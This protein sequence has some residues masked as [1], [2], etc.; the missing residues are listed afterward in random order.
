M[1]LGAYQIES[2][3]KIL[4]RKQNSLNL[5]LND[6]LVI[7][8]ENKRGILTTIKQCALPSEEWPHIE[9]EL[10]IPVRQG[11]Y[12]LSKSWRIK[13]D[14]IPRQLVEPAYQ[15]NSD[16]FCAYLDTDK[17]DAELHLR[18]WQPGDRYQPMGMHGKTIK[19]S[20]FWV[21]QKLPQRARKF[22]PLVFSGKQLVW[23]PGFQPSHQARITEGTREILM[24]K[25]EKIT[26]EN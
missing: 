15:H 21:N 10:T 23:I 19:L 20:D 9:Q 4:A 25:I 1:D 5:Q 12:A 22:W 26:A 13:S 3:R 6:Q 2:A 16:S 18:S 14:V 7:R 8:I 17:L 11:V 24:L